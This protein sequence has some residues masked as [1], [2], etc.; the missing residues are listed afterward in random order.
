MADDGEFTLFAPPSTAGSSNTL[1]LSSNSIGPG[2]TGVAAPLVSRTLFPSPTPFVAVTGREEQEDD[3]RGV[4]R[5]TIVY[6][7]VLPNLT[8]R[9][10]P[11]AQGKAANWNIDLMGVIQ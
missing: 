7:N 8:I 4:K 3:V 5:A 10:Q 2:V 6:E 1:T 11:A 9:G